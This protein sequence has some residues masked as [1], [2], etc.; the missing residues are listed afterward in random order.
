[1]AQQEDGCHANSVLLRHNA[2]V[3]TDVFRFE[4][5]KEVPVDEGICSPD[6]PPWIAKDVLATAARETDTDDDPSTFLWIKIS[7]G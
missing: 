4:A 2:V 6:T 7:H 1:M 5:G 3:I